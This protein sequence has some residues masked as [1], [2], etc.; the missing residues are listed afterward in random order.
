MDESERNADVRPLAPRVTV[1]HKIVIGLVALWALMMT[2]CF[3]GG[4][5]GSEIGQYQLTEAEVHRIPSRLDLLQP[6]MTREIVW[7]TLV[8]GSRQKLTW[9][10]LVYGIIAEE[11]G[12]GRRNNRQTEK[13]RLRPGCDL[14][15]EFK[16]TLG[17]QH[18]SYVRG[19]LEGTGWPRGAPGR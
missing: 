17:E 19:E 14:W 3:G 16:F 5:V 10:P 12:V 6:G 1:G 11:R 8:P 4:I 7:D 2:C 9:F 18:E 15:L 13:Y